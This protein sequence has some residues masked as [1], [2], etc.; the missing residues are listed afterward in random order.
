MTVLTAETLKP[1]RLLLAL[2]AVALVL[3]A[4]AKTNYKKWLQEEVVRIV[5]GNRT[6]YRYASAFGVW[7]ASAGAR[8]FSQP[9]N[10]AGTA[11]E[12]MVR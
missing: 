12:G 2:A 10:R 9:R 4:Y 6:A 5:S 1:Q 7:R 11:S 8:P 3:P